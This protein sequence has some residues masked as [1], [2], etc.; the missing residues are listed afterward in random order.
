MVIQAIAMFRPLTTGAFRHP[1][2]FIVASGCSTIQVQTSTYSARIDPFHFPQLHRCPRLGILY[3]VGRNLIGIIRGKPGAGQRIGEC[4]I[5]YWQVL[6][7]QWRLAAVAAAGVR[8]V[9]SVKHVWKRIAGRPRLR[10]VLASNKSPTNPFQAAIKRVWSAFSRTRNWRRIPASQTALVMSGSGTA[11]APSQILRPRYVVQQTPSRRCDDIQSAIKIPRI[12]GVGHIG[13]CHQ[14]HR[15][16]IA[17]G[18]QPFDI[19][20]VLPVHCDNQVKSIEIRSREL[21]CAQ[22]TQVD[23]S[24]LCRR[25]HRTVRRITHM[26]STCPGTIQYQVGCKLAHHAFGRR[27]AADIP[28]ADKDNSHQRNT[29]RLV[30]ARA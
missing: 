12:I 13:I 9:P 17:L 1:W 21:P 8:Q 6:W 30:M 29:P 14:A 15:R 27:R 20:L 11:T 3:H 19:V 26:P 5:S 2:Q 22:P 28:K 18:P 23:P 25:L 16:R 10:C 7:H 24:G 4:G